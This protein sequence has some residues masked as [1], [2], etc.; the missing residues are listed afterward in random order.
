MYVGKLRTYYWDYSAPGPPVTDNNTPYSS[1]LMELAALPGDNIPSIAVGEIRDKTG[2]RVATNYGGST[3]LSQG[4]SEMVISAFYKTR[5]VHV[6]ERLDTSVPALENR[7]AQ[8]GM[9]S[10]RAFVA[11]VAPTDF[12][13][14]GALTELNYNIS[15][16]AARLFVAGV[17]VGTKQAVINVGLDLRVVDS[18]TLRTV[19]VFQP[20]K[21]NNRI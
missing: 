13:V 4:V 9:A 17:G 18:K 3:M 19:Y 2:Q 10:K 20:S 14:L 5:K 11:N 16:S 1:C 8:V 21:A 6:A 15:S 7:F 12:I